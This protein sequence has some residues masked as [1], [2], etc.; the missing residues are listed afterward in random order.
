MKASL[1]ISLAQIFI[2]LI[3]LPITIYGSWLLYKHVQATEL[4]WFIW[5]LSMPLVIV[6]N[7][8]AQIIKSVSEK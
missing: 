8:F 1:I 4:M 7:L 2:G 3:S 5:W 6:T